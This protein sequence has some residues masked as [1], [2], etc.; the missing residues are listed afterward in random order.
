MKTIIFSVL[1]AAVLICS[2]YLVWKEPNQLNSLAG[3][4]LTIFITV[5]SFLIGQATNE[6][7]IRREATSKWMPAAE[8]ACKELIT[9]SGTVGRLQS[10]QGQLCQQMEGFLDDNC[11][12]NAI[13]LRNLI[14]TKCHGCSNELTTVKQQL[15][16][17]AE[18]WEV[19]LTANCETGECETIMNRIKAMKQRAVIQNPTCQ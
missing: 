11:G 7:K 13:I 9:I 5:F 3:L 10:S 16:L 15:D 1:L 8:S 2:F 12:Q 19:F 6:K 17:S 18:N 14:E 4:L